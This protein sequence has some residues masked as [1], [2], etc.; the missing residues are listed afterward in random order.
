[1]SHF[2]ICDPYRDVSR[3][4]DVSQLWV[5]FEDLHLGHSRKG[6]LCLCEARWSRGLLGVLP[7]HPAGLLREAVT[8]G[9]AHDWPPCSPQKP[10]RPAAHRGETS[11]QSFVGLD[12]PSRQSALGWSA[13]I[14]H[15]ITIIQCYL[16]YVRQNRSGGYEPVGSGDRRSTTT[17]EE[18]MQKMCS[19]SR[20]MLCIFGRCSGNFENFMNDLSRAMWKQR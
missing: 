19:N 3:S 18:A 14:M 10:S 5:I 8:P 1:M 6:M 2:G 17:Q 9:E 11:Q 13:K 7:L 20:R 4:Q 16:V 12:M 15:C